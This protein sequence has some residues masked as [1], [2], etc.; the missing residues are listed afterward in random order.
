MKKF[1]GKRPHVPGAISWRYSEIFDRKKLMK[2]PVVFGHIWNTT[3]IEMLGNSEAGCCV[4]STQAHLLNNMQ[5]GFSDTTSKF[6]EASVLGDYSAATGYVPGD[7]AT[8]RG[9]SM[10]DGAAYWR[11]VGIADASGFRHRIDAYVDMNIRNVDDLI[12]AAFDFGGIALGVKLPRSADEQWEQGRPWT[13]V[14]S[15]AIIGGHAVSLIGRNSN[16]HA[17]I[18]TWDGIASATMDWVQEYAD[19]AVAFVSL[20]YLDERGMNPRGFNKAEMLK[21]LAALGTVV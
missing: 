15:S 17:I 11:K 19:E 16:G 13:V 6:S 1:L 21:R 2:P 20:S 4:W 9:T 5:R 7:D 8:D 14:R 10:A 12:Q 3:L 18:A